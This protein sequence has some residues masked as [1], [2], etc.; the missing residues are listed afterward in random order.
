MKKHLLRTLGILFGLFLTTWVMAKQ[1][2]PATGFEVTPDEYFETEWQNNTKI[3]VTTQQIMTMYGLHV[4]MPIQGPEF[5]ARAF[6]F[7]NQRDLGLQD[8]TLDDLSLV[9]TRES[10]IG[11]TLR[12]QQS[13]QGYPVYKSQVVVNIN[14]EQEIAY[15]MSDYRMLNYSVPQ[16]GFTSAQA[17]ERAYAHL[18]IGTDYQ[19]EQIDV[20]IYPFGNTPRLAY[21]VRVQEQSLLGEWE[22]LVDAVTGEIFKVVDNA[23]YYDAHAHGT[24]SAAATGTGNTFDPDPLTSATV[25]YGGG[26]VDGSDATSAQLAAEITTVSLLDITL[27]GGLHF[28]SGPWC[29]IVEFD[30]PNKGVF[31]QASSTWNGDR[32]ADEFEAVTCYYHVDASMRYINNTLG[33][34]IQ[35]TLYSSG[36]RVDAHGANGADN[37]YYTGGTQ[38]LAFGEGCVDDGEDSDVIHHELMHGLHDWATGGNLSNNEGLS[39]GS[40]DYWAVSYT[41]ASGNWTSA[42]DQWDWVFQWDGHNTCWGGRVTDY[43]GTY[44]D[45]ITSGCLHTCGQ[46]WS[47]CIMGIW[48]QLG[49]NT[50][51]KLMLEGLGL[52]G[53][54]SDQNDAAVGFLQASANLGLSSAQKTLIE[55][56][57]TGCGYDVSS[58]ILPIELTRFTAH[59]ENDQEVLLHWE[60]ASEFNNEGFEILRKLEGES[61]FKRVGFQVGRDNSDETIHY[62]FID[63]NAS[64]SK[65]YYQLRQLDFDGTETLSDIEV[66]AG[67]APETL[68]VYPNPAKSRLEIAFGEQAQRPFGWSITNASGE[69][70]RRG[71]QVFNG[72]GRATIF[73]I[74][75]L[76][77]GVYF[78]TIES[79]SQ[80]EVR[81][82]VKE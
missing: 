26:Y 15:V 10:T 33:C 25:G 70:L 48:D 64:P 66:V 59:R 29:E 34:N 16:I 40:A 75:T 45:N 81:K 24:S 36:V 55:G 50:T 44:P 58:V 9:F 21:V 20:M 61:S 14:P 80:V 3:N 1:P 68:H 22:V 73:D 71:E 18:N 79:E 19:F 63:Q 82:F 8:P 76:T 37:S 30:N 62:S 23:V 28:L 54:G 13:L 52:T 12:F 56:A 7:D 43:G 17:K 53:S 49:K 47:T 65:S 57:L 2:K 78:I 69:L 51:D 35:P 74:N 6:L 11:T 77:P 41:R 39:E 72:E 31:S 42:D 46:I 60:T 38:R 4:K 5:M 67:R 32:T 27:T